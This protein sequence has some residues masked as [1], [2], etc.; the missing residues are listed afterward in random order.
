MEDFDARCFVCDKPLGA[1]DGR[2]ERNGKKF[3]NFD[4]YRVFHTEDVICAKLRDVENA[5][6]RLALI[7]VKGKRIG[8]GSWR[9]KADQPERK[10]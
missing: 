10:K 2:L 7:L 8:I 5:V 1:L 6:D 3:C 9:P 4:C